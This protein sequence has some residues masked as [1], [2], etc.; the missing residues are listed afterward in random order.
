M[1]TEG[2]VGKKIKCIQKLATSQYFYCY[3]SKPSSSLIRILVVASYLVIS[4]LP[5]SHQ[6]K[7]WSQIMSLLYSTTA[8][9]SLKIKANP[10]DDLD[11]SLVSSLTNSLTRPHSSHTDLTFPQISAACFYSRSLITFSDWIALSSDGLPRPL[12]T[13]FPSPC[14]S[15]LLGT[16][17]DLR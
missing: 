3:W 5:F 11:T 7:N 1:Y 4:P 15:F 6:F 14:F 8:P 10:L 9:T 2:W 12:S 16:L 17:I 13:I